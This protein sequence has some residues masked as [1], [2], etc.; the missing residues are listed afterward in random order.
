MI[1]YNPPAL[2]TRAS[3]V[4]AAS[5]NR[6]RGKSEHQRAASPLTAGSPGEIPN[7]RFQKWDVVSR[8]PIWHLA[9]RLTGATTSA[10]ENRPADRVSDSKIW[11]LNAG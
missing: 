7:S 11:D 2:Q 4:I 3:R 1:C 9:R 5:R 6:R 10:T 8:I